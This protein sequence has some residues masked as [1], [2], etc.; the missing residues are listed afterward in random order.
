MN[1]IRAIFKARKISK[2]IN[3]T[4]YV[5]KFKP[6]VRRD[7]VSTLFRYENVSQDYIDFRGYKGKKYY[8]TK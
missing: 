5:V 1:L 8:K 6:K 7:S 2:I 3:D 4:C